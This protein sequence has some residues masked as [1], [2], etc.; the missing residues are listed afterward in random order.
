MD[1]AI[2]VYDGFTALDATGPFEVLSRLPDVRVRFVAATP[3][4]TAADQPGFALAAGPLEDMDRPD[5]VVVAGG[6]TTQGFLGDDAI[7]SWLRRVHGTSRWTTSV[8]TGSLLLGAAGLLRGRRATTHWYELESL[9]RFGAEPVP[10]RVVEDGRIMTAAG[11]SS[12]I[13]MALHVVDRLQGPAYAQAV[14]LGIE[15]DPQPPHDAGSVAKAPAE[16]VRL[17][18]D[19]MRRSYGPSWAELTPTTT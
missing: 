16:V 2:L 15:Y 14:Q 19:A 1:V 9:R 3:G 8:C 4:T 12:G 18:T 11:V 5:V 6:S 7:L 17:M 10:E 13:D